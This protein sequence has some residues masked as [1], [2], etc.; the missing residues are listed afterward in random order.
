MGDTE[1]N[2]SK[3][4]FVISNILCYI[5]TARHSHRVDDIVRTCYV[6]YKPDTITKGKDLLY[7]LCGESSKRRRGENRLVQELQDIVDLLE[8]VEEKN[9]KL[10]T[11]VVDSYNGLPPSSG[12]ELVA[13]HIVSLNE[14]ISSLRKE[15]EAL[16]EMRLNENLFCQGNNILQE[17]LMFIKGELG[18]LIIS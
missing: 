5:S 12:F 4:N 13:A 11:F 6:F 17:D 7:D 16:R 10:P 1:I 14:E 18:N 2:V 15:V 9:I 3:E 8:K